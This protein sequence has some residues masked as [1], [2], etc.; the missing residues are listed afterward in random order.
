MLQHD[1]D[2]HG[3]SAQN[4]SRTNASDPK[5]TS[6]MSQTTVANQSAEEQPTQSMTN[7]TGVAQQ[8]GQNC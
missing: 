7:A 3:P 2:K 1:S 8:Q 4:S 5:V 6:L